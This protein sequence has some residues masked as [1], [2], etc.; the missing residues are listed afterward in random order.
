MYLFSYIIDNQKKD[1]IFRIE[2]KIL[3]RKIKLM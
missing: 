1:K 3:E 2:N